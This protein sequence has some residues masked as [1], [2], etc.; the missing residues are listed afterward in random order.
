MKEKSI[1][2]KLLCINYN[3][4]TTVILQA[5]SLILK[6]VSTQKEGLI[7]YNYESIFFASI[8]YELFAEKIAKISNYGIDEYWKNCKAYNQITPLSCNV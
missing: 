3:V 5:S 7:V 6:N 2:W 8:F 4:A 1:Y